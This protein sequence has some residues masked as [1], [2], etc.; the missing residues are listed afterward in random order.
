MGAAGFKEAP[1]LDTVELELKGNLKLRH[2]GAAALATNAPLSP[3]QI[4]GSSCL[5][6]GEG[7]E[8]NKDE[9]IWGG[10][11]RSPRQ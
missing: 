2:D 11:L 5:D 1:S 8:H 10:D 6:F 9:L 7:D 4:L 3:P